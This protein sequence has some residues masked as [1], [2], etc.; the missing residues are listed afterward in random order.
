MKVSTPK[1]NGWKIR[2]LLHCNYITYHHISVFSF[3]TRAQAEPPMEW[4]YGWEALCPQ[5][6]AIK[7]VMKYWNWTY[8]LINQGPCWIA[9]GRTLNL[10]LCIFL[11]TVYTYT[12]SYLLWGLP[13]LSWVAL[14]N[15]RCAQAV[16]SA[17]ICCRCSTKKAARWS[18]VHVGKFWGATKTKRFFLY[19]GGKQSWYSRISWLAS[20]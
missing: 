5:N 3:A 4:F 16:P 18:D 10:V 9:A 19:W 6:I 11:N 12:V 1:R 8:L 13:T 2:R 7:C 17:S 20:W 15:H 14:F